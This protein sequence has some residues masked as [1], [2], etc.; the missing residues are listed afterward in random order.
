MRWSRKTKRSPRRFS[1]SCHDVPRAHV[2]THV[3]ARQPSKANKGTADA[4]A[5]ARRQRARA[6]AAPTRRAIPLLGGD[7]LVR[8]H[9]Y[10]NSRKPLG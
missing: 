10:I 8:T 1:P 3:C 5:R 7:A 4:R 9:V 6:R 2:T